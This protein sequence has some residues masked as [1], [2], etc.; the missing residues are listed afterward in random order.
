VSTA[1]CATMQDCPT[2][3]RAVRSGYVGARSV[4]MGDAEKWTVSKTLIALV[5][6][7][8]GRFISPLDAEQSPVGRRHRTPRKSKVAPAS[9]GNITTLPFNERLPVVYVIQAEG[10]LLKIGTSKS[11]GAR[12]RGLSLMSPVK[13]EIVALFNGTSKDER[14]FHKHFARHRHHG[15][16]F[17]PALEILEWAK[18]M[19]IRR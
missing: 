12:F 17:E 2:S 18:E 10:G 11:F 7:P 14:A 9:I 19:G 8:N 13:L 5:P 16:W 3:A 4:V 6:G 15:E 1:V